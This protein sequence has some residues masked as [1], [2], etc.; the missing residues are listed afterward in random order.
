[1]N[2][3]T[4]EMQW[5]GDIGVSGSYRWARVVESGYGDDSEEIMVPMAAINSSAMYFFSRNMQLSEARRRIYNTWVAR[6]QAVHHKLPLP[7]SSEKPNASN[8]Q[9]LTATF[10]NPR[11]SQRHY[12]C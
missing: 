7:I 9:S 5:T 10:S 6:L 11:G 12:K 8:H 3:Q 2:H 4:R 1:M